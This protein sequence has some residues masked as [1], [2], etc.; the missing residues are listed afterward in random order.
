MS[1]EL[2]QVLIFVCT[3][4]IFGSL[5]LFT[6]FIAQKLLRIGNKSKLKY[7]PYEC[8]VKPD[9]NFTGLFDIKYYMFVLL[10]IVFDVEFIF[11]IPWAMYF[12]KLET[13]AKGEP[14]LYFLLFE[15][16]MFVAILG[17]GWFYALKNKA[18]DWADSN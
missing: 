8:G 1:A 2:I 15:A 11:L 16:V 12:A 18:L 6:S 17:L 9:E 3:A 10:F 13:I 5:L 4:L 14:S 7:Q